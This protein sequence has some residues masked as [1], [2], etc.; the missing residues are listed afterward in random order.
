MV[1][2]VKFGSAKKYV[3]KEKKEEETKKQGRVRQS[4]T[5]CEWWPIHRCYPTTV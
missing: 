4:R 1:F 3:I 5:G 2:K